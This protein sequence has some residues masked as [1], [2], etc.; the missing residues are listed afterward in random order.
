MARRQSAAIEKRPSGLQSAW[1]GSLLTILSGLS[2][3]FMCM[4]IPLVGKAAVMTSHAA[5]NFYTFLAI[6]LLSLTLAVLA[7]IS[8]LERR[9][10]DGSPLPWFSFIL[11]GV[12]LLL[13]VSLLLGLLK[14]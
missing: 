5:A 9:K 10:V 13:L 3:L 2:F 1:F 8:K 6:L 12:C 7:T 11:V 4:T 14:I